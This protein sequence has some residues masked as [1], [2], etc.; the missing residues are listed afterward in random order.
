MRLDHFVLTVRS[1]DDTVDFYRRALG[2]EVV[3]FGDGR[4]ALQ[5]G[6]QK[7]NL[8]QAGREFEPKARHPTPGSGDFCIVIDQP[9]DE[10][11]DRLRRLG[12]PI[13]EGPVARTGAVGPLLSIYVRDPDQNLVE[14]ANAR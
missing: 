12:I 2:L 11:I 1:I 5:V 14:I 7:V 3:T 10:V 8:H 4:R 13:E 9:L 6:E